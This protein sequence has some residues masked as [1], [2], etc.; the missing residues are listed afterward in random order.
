MSVGNRSGIGKRPMC[1][2]ILRCSSSVACR[3]VFAPEVVVGVVMVMSGTTIDL[4]STR[5]G[6]T[7][8]DGRADEGLL[9]FLSW[10]VR[11]DGPEP[12]LAAREG[13]WDCVL[14]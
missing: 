7:S 13:D 1:C 9:C 3:G 10:S 11:L 4:L 2:E 12:L 6:E 5:I 8:R 14:E